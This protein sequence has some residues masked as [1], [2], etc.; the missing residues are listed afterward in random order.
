MKITGVGPVTPAGI[1]RAAFWSGIQ[2]SVSRIKPFTKLGEEWGPFIAGAVS[3]A[4]L[5]EC[6]REIGAVYPRHLARHSLF[7][8]AA[9]SLAVRDA[10]IAIEELRAKTTAIVVGTSVMDFGSITHAIRSVANKGLRGVFPRVVTTANVT[11]VAS[12]ICET[13]GI[14]GCMQVIQSSCCSGLDAVGNAARIIAG[15]QADVA[16]AGGA[17]APLHLHPLIEFRAIELT[18]ATFD[19]A[20]KHCRPFDLWRT[21]GTISEGAAM[22]ILEPEESPREALAWVSGHAFQNDKPGELCGGLYDSMRYAV[23]EAGLRLDEIDVLSASG[24]GH[25]L[26][27]KAEAAEIRRLFGEEIE[28]LAIYSIKGAIGNALGGAPAIQIAAGALGLRESVIPPTVNW[29]RPDPS[30][31]LNLSNQARRLDHRN[32]LINS[33]GRGGENSAMVLSR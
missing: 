31:S 13:L 23:I 28:R 32:V 26:V 18:P 12:A 14:T 16:I 29:L 22:L 8:A 5:Q 7:G 17:E 1:G 19:N 21:T 11:H 25:R 27:D 10:G 24:P 3:D 6:S 30:C 2:E 9:A 33:H 20:E 4:E 15:G